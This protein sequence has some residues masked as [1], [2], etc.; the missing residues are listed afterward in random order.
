MCISQ[1]VET[2]A[3]LKTSDSAA[4]TAFL[5]AAAPQPSQPF[6]DAAW[7]QNEP[8]GSNGGGGSNG[9][10]R[11]NSEDGGGRGLQNDEGRDASN[12]CRSASEQ[13]D[14]WRALSV[15]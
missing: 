13:S 12:I 5:E 10:G 4:V 8:G 3:A 9:R 7:P 6:E 1:L 2:L 15:E 14:D 11:E